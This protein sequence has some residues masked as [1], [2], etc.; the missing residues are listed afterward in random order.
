M[1]TQKF[2]DQ[3]EWL[4]TTPLEKLDDINLR[5]CWCDGVLKPDKDTYSVESVKRTKMVITKA[6]I[7]EGEIKGKERGRGQSL[8][9]RLYLL[10]IHFGEQ[11]YKKFMNKQEFIDC[12]P[13]DE[14][15]DWLM[16]DF[17]KKEIEIQLL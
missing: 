13:D 16:F 7:D 17:E 15:G 3:L 6:W 4:L 12:I 10:T 11:S 5:R 2:C 14:S 9:Q 8:G 1:V